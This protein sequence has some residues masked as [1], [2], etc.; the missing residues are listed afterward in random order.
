MGTSTGLPDP[1]STRN[2]RQQKPS[3]S[4]HT[5]HSPI[6]DKK[7]HNYK[8]KKSHKN[9]IC[10]QTQMNAPMNNRKLKTKNKTSDKQMIRRKGRRTN[11]NKGA[12]EYTASATSILP[13]VEV[14][15]QDK[16][17]SWGHH[18]CHKPPNTIR[19]LLQNIGGIDAN[20]KGSVKLAALH[21]FM[22]EHQVDITAI[23]ECNVAWS[24]VDSELSPQEQTRFWWE[25]AH[26]SVTHNRKDPDAAKYQP[27]GASLVVVN[28]LS[29]RAQRPGDDTVGLGRWCWARLRGKNNQHLR[30]ISAYRPCPSLGPLS[31]YQQQVRYWSSIR[32]NCCPRAKWL[33]DLQHQILQWQEEGDY[34]VLLADMNEDVIS[35]DI[36]KFCQE[37]NL[38]EAISSLHGRSPVPTHQRGSKAIDGIYVSP[39][40]L[41]YAE[42]GILALG[43]VTP[44]D[45][46]AIWLDIKAT[47][48]AMDQQDQVVHPQ[49]RRL[50]CHDPRVVERYTKS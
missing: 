1:G 34:I 11:A 36:Q 16:Q 35:I 46:R 24:Q 15:L 32:I 30:L 33:T 45:H 14:T 21:E 19:V 18:M 20:H 5:N 7:Q 22:V 8:R 41:E 50:K 42:G 12:L 23:T 29:H 28:Q 25:N 2:S 9:I 27:G 10:R 49:C 40:L 13:G 44:S 31:T 48:I 38:V 39:A 26:W 47:T 17:D 3:G 6:Y 37:L 43:S 4:T